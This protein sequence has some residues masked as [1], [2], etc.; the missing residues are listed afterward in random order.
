M[1]VPQWEPWLFRTLSPRGRYVENNLTWL[2]H[3][4][5]P[6]WCKC[7]NE[8]TRVNIAYHVNH[9][10]YV[11]SWHTEYLYNAFRHV[12]RIPWPSVPMTMSYATVHRLRKSRTNPAGLCLIECGYQAPSP[13][14]AHSADLNTEYR[15]IVSVPLLGPLSAH[16]VTM[17]IERT[18]QRDHWMRI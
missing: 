17:Q 10:S 16:P 2:L 8:T 14:R 9:P 6:H 7:R 3:K 4:Y 12:L 15:A 5:I 11:S 1:Q 13:C 18:V